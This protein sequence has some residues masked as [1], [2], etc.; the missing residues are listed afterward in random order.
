MDSQEN[1]GTEAAQDIF[2]AQTLVLASLYNDGPRPIVESR[3]YQNFLTQALAARNIRFI[4]LFNA[5]GTERNNMEEIKEMKAEENSE[6][7]KPLFSEAK[8]QLLERAHRN[9]GDVTFA[10]LDLRGVNFSG[11]SFAG[12]DF[13]GSNCEGVDFDRSQLK[14]CNF[15]GAN[16][17]KAEFRF[18][19]LTECN[20]EGADLS[21]AVIYTN[22][23]VSLKA[24][25]ANFEG[26]ELGPSIFDRSDF[27]G[28]SFVNIIGHRACFSYCD[29]TGADFTGARLDEANLIGAILNN[30]NMTDATMRKAHFSTDPSIDGWILK[31]TILLGTSLEKL[32]PRPFNKANFLH[33]IAATAEV[34]ELVK[35][36]TTEEEVLKAIFEFNQKPKPKAPKRRQN[37]SSVLFVKAY[38][39]K[40]Q[41]DYIAQLLRITEAIKTADRRTS[42]GTIRLS[43]QTPQPL[44]PLISPDIFEHP[45]FK[46]RRIKEI[47]KRGRSLGTVIRVETLEDVFYTWEGNKINAGKFNFIISLDH[48]NIRFIP[49]EENFTASAGPYIHNQD[50]CLGANSDSVYSKIRNGQ[51]CDAL[52]ELYTTMTRFNTS[53]TPYVGIDTLFQSA[54]DKRLFRNNGN[55]VK[56]EAI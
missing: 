5:L 1:S 31:N 53:S 12:A 44:P 38:N 36:L 3:Q 2:R 55:L 39:E 21:G 33:V 17:R 23:A 27:R 45:L 29:F 11:R 28:A 8:L 41:T 52:T 7:I 14:A 49:I 56:V 34:R 46:V 20:F 16:L 51:I 6:P 54:I 25:D 22:N 35:D 10:N 50:V 47:I 4:D 15:Q 24:R 40:I 13:S 30:A 19:D 26:A 43:F 9:K 42:I 37:R 48:L 32:T 18:T